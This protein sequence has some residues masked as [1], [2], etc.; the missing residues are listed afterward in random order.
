MTQAWSAGWRSAITLGDACN[1]RSCDHP[2]HFGQA[3]AVAQLQ[4]TIRHPSRSW[5]D[6]PRMRALNRWPGSAHRLIHRLASLGVIAVQSTLGCAGGIRFTFGVRYWHRSPIRR[7]NVARMTSRR[8]PSPGQIELPAPAHAQAQP[9]PT[10]SPPFPSGSF[11]D[12]M[13]AAGFVPPW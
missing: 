10:G 8:R 4:A 1:R 12:L 6:A 7:A 13:L 11:S 9:G 2:R 3:H 5:H